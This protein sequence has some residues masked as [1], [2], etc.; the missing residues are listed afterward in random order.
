MYLHSGNERGLGNIYYT[1]LLIILVIVIIYLWCDFGG[2]LRGSCPAI[3]R[4]SE[5][6][7]E[8]VNHFLGI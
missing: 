6:I 5:K 8:E 2:S 3:Y 4:W 1:L 7:T